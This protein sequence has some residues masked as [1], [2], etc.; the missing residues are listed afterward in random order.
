MNPLEE[1]KAVI[2]TELQ[3]VTEED[4]ELAQAVAKDAS[5]L[6]ARALQGEDVT[7]EIRLRLNRLLMYVVDTPSALASSPWLIS[8]SAM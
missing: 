5:K 7:A 4:K 1:I 2:E 8:N 3:D 6:A